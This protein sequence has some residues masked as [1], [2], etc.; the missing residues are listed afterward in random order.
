MLVIAMRTSLLQLRSY[1]LVFSASLCSLNWQVVSAS[2][3]PKRTLVDNDHIIV[4][5]MFPHFTRQHL[6]FTTWLD[7]EG[8]SKAAI[9]RLLKDPALAPLTQ[10]LSWRSEKQMKEK[11]S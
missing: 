6:A 3:L 1:H 5:I 2:L 11:V 7:E 9:G 4:T 8:I 10:G